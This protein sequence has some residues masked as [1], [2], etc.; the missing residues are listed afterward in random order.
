MTTSNN[1]QARFERSTAEGRLAEMAYLDSLTDEQLAGLDPDH[2]YVTRNPA[3]TS[4]QR[5]VLLQR[6]TEAEG[7]LDNLAPQQP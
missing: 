7:R 2:R 3:E 1:R 5:A 6:L 4:Q